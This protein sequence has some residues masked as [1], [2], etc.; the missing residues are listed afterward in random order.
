MGAGG[1][2]GSNIA[3]G[4]LVLGRVFIF[5]VKWG[6]LAKRETLIEDP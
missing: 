1:R 3:V 5:T 6:I 4:R 2:E